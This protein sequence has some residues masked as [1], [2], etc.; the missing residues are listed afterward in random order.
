LEIDR[1]DP[2]EAGQVLYHLA[3]A[4][5]YGD[6]GNR[7]VASVKQDLESG[8][9]LIILDVSKLQRIDSGG[10]GLLAAAL[11]SARNAGGEI[12]LTGMNERYHK[13]F[14]VVGL[15][16]MFGFTDD[17]PARGK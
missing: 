9:R 15:S 4:L 17:D 10:I 6:P 14:Q 13:L 7:L 3:G 16:G 2:D 1:K 12:H 5:S 8:V 11:A